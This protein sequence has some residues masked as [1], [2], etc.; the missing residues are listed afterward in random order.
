MKKYRF[1]LRK[2]QQASISEVCSPDETVEDVVKRI[3]K[4]SEE[5]LEFSEPE[6][7]LEAI[8]R[9]EGKLSRLLWLFR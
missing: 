9:E 7:H 8:S 2:V 3:E 1:L 6:Y 5:D 4:M